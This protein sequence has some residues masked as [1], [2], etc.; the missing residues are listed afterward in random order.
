MNYY[1]VGVYD[2]QIVKG[3]DGKPKAKA[4]IVEPYL[5][6]F[7]ELAEDDPALGPDRGYSMA[8]AIVLSSGEGVADEQGNIIYNIEQA[9]ELFE[10]ASM[11]KNIRD[12]FPNELQTRRQWVLW[13]EITDK[14]N[15][16]HFSKQPFSP[17]TGMQLSGGH[18][19][20][21]R[22]RHY[23]TFND[24]ETAAFK[25]R[26][27]V[28]FEVTEA[29]PFAVV[30]FDKAIRD[31]AIHPAVCDLLKYL[32]GYV[33]RSVS[34]TGLH[35]IGLGKA[36]KNL[37]PT[38]VVEGEQLIKVEVYRHHFVVCTGNNFGFE[39]RFN[40]QSG[41][42][43]QNIQMGVDR[44]F[45][46]KS[47]EVPYLG[48][49][50]TRPEAETH[51]MSKRTAKRIYA[52]N[53]ETLRHATHGEGN[54][55]LNSCAFFAGRAFSAKALDESEVEIKRELFQI[56]TREWHDPHSADGAKATIESG[57][58]SGVGN[59]LAIKEE[60]DLEKFFAKYSEE[61]GYKVTRNYGG[62]TRVVGKERDDHPAFDGRWQLA[63]QSFEEFKKAHIED[64]AFIRKGA[65]IVVLYAA[66]EWLEDLATPR[67]EKVIFQPERK[68][69]DCL[70]L[71]QGWAV[72]P[73][74]GDCSIYLDHIREVI[75][76]SNEEY[77]N[78]I[79]KWMAYAVQHPN[80]PGCTAL[81]WRED[82]GVGKNLAADGFGNLWGQHYLTLTNPEHFL[83]RFNSHMRYCSVL[84]A[85]EAFYAGNK[86]HEAA[87]KAL[88]TDPTIAIEQKFVDIKMC[89]NLVHTI[90]LSNS[91]WVVPA[92]PGERRYF[93]LDVSSKRKGDKGYFEK[94]AAQ[95]TKPN[96][97]L[98][99]HLLHMDLKDYSPRFVPS[100]PALYSQMAEGLEGADAAWFECLC[101]G[102]LPGRLQDDK[103]IHMTSTE[104]IKWAD[105]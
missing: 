9:T 51:P 2:C 7:D 17:L 64:K 40:N 26:L 13:K 19:S 21:E 32:P 12:N 75:C 80:E 66:E 81:V 70:N 25:Y 104:F 92:T 50:A 31:G 94:L 38:A 33:E 35:V 6:E 16:G 36:L 54:H 67:F 78:H 8:D 103:T 96:A 48:K 1:P 46:G 100:T 55:L 15:P 60:T 86:Q 76:S 98:L 74:K 11:L 65:E 88:V 59:P 43:L 37:A 34:G 4:E 41:S 3:E 61:K 29:D 84:C 58:N 47:K 27:G 79:I 102:E 28:G 95:V 20:P 97:A 57:W 56:V 22:E 73:E 23:L 85:N 82:K 5:I 72:P 45:Q 71:W 42:K 24:V 18:G 93:V 69:D 14:N 63:A 52:D 105:N 90:V 87:L 62:K 99:Y 30:D 44:I 83:G 89:P 39:D 101:R 77:Y 53:L 49:E 68:I 91:D 10:L